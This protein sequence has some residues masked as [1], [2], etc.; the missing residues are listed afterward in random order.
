M[1]ESLPSRSD[2]IG[3]NP[4]TSGDISGDSKNYWVARRYIIIT[5]IEVLR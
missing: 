5:A 4:Q 2:S 3:V 1:E